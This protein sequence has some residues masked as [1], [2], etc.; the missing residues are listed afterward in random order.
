MNSPIPD[1]T[2]ADI[3]EQT[4]DWSWLAADLL[5]SYYRGVDLG[6]RDKGGNDPVTIADEAVNDYILDRLQSL[7]GDRCGYLTEET[8]QVGFT[9]LPQDWVWIIDPLDGT[10]DFIDKTGEYAIHI[11]LTY[12]GRPVLAVVAVPEKGRLYCAIAGEGSFAID[13]RGERTPLRVA[14]DRRLEDLTVLASRNHVT[15]RL[16]A[17][18]DR[19]PCH[20]Q[21]QV[22]SVGC[23]IATIVDREADLYIS[24]SGKSAPKEWDMAAP[25]LILTEAGGKFTH[26]DGSPLKYNQ[27]DVSQWG[28]LLASSGQWHQ[29]LLEYLDSGNSKVS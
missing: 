21:K 2:L 23:K 25:E 18:L 27:S 17:I 1:L 19:L 16:Q 20:Q 29:E 7:Y 22:G 8:Y 12:K 15:E 10:R 5:Q 3:L 6:V 28:C 26:V 24:L 9:P 13:R 11:A 14:Q 4:I